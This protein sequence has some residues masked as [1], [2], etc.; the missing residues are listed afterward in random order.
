MERAKFSE[1]EEPQ[2]EDAFSELQELLRQESLDE[3]LELKHRVRSLLDKP[4]ALAAT[5]CRIAPTPE[6]QETETTPAVACHAE[7]CFRG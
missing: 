4:S 6:I 1:P 7:G 3:Q 2:L 5:V